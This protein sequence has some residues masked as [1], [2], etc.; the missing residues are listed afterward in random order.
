M[1]SVHTTAIED[2]RQPSND[3]EQDS[4]RRHKKHRRQV[5]CE[6]PEIELDSGAH[7]EKWIKPPERK[8]LHFIPQ[9]A[10]AFAA[11]A[12]AEDRSSGKRAGE[13]FKS[14]FL[15]EKQEAGQHKHRD[16]YGQL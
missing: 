10:A 9:H 14:K 15:R 7:E 11:S 12:R 13:T 6:R 8:R 2:R 4:D 3:E 5:V 1:R 16:T